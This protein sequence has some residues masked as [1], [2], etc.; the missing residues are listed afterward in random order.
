MQTFWNPNTDE[1]QRFLYEADNRKELKEKCDEH[2]SKMEESGWE[3][4]NRVEEIGRNDPCPCGSERKFKKCCMEHLDG[5]S[6]IK[7]ESRSKY[8]P[9]QGKQEMERRALD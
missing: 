8:T 1:I 4:S 3:L 7:I 2:K 5:K 6:Q 9:H